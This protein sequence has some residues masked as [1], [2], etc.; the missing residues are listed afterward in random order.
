MKI[1]DIPSAQLH[2]EDRAVSQN[3]WWIGGL[4]FLPGLLALVWL[5]ETYR[6]M[7]L[8]GWM[9]IW[10]VLLFILPRRW[11]EKVCVTLD[12]QRKEIVWK[13]NERLM[14]TVPFAEIKEFDLAQLATA[15]RPY[16]TYQLFVSLKNG[17]RITLA[18]D[19]HETEIRK[20]LKLAREKFR[21]P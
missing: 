11:G 14:R 12:S 7:G 1:I 19:S 15:S 3:V 9:A 20:A 4:L 6:F 21:Q 16:K 8:L 5:P 10:L 18:V 2:L 13:R 17:N